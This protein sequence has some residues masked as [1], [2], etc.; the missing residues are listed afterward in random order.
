MKAGICAEAPTAL[1]VDDEERL[2]LLRAVSTGSCL[3]RAWSFWEVCR[4]ESRATCARSGRRREFRRRRAR[5][6]SGRRAPRRVRRSPSR[7]SLPCFS[8]YRA[9]RV[10]ESGPKSD[11]PQDRTHDLLRRP[12]QKVNGSS[13]PEFTCKRAFFESTVRSVGGGSGFGPARCKRTSRLRTRKRPANAGLLKAAEG[14][15]TLDLLHG[16]QTL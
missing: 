11:A 6:V 15:R 14:I 2:E 8:R 5:R 10:A 12:S 16:K 1:A 4:A 3:G 13:D 7:R 9:A